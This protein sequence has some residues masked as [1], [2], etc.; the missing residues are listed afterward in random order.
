M[1]DNEQ[2][3]VNH[4]QFI[5]NCYLHCSKNYNSFLLFF[6]FGKTNDVFHLVG[7]LLLGMFIFNHLNP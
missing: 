6:L 7:C 1:Y 5:D 4:A 3:I 2:Y